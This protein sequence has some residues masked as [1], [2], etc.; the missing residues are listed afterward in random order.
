MP[1]RLG[2]KRAREAV[3]FSPDPPKADR[4]NKQSLAQW[5]N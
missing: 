3:R 2:K 5:P 4:M 1:V